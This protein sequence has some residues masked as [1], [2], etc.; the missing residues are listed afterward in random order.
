VGTNFGQNGGP[1]V[2]PSIDLLGWV[3]ELG[4]A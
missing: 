1:I 4:R 2:C 3:P